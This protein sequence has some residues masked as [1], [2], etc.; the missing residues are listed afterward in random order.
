MGGGELS[1][2]VVVLGKLLAM[3]PVG[4]AITRL[5]GGDGALAQLSFIYGTLPVAP[6]VSIYALRYASCT[7]AATN[8]VAQV[9][10]HPQ[11][12][13]AGKQA[14]A[15]V[16]TGCLVLSGP[17][18]LSS[19]TVLSTVVGVPLLMMLALA[20][21][22]LDAQPAALPTLTSE[23]VSRYLCWPA[24]LGS[25][26]VLAS[27]TAEGRTSLLL[28]GPGGGRG[29]GGGGGFLDLYLLT[30][31]TAAKTLLTPM[32]ALLPR[33]TPLLLLACLAQRVWA[34]QLGLTTYLRRRFGPSAVLR[35]W[36]RL[37]AASLAVVLAVWFASLLLLSASSTSVGS[38]SSSLRHEPL[39]VVPLLL[40]RLSPLLLALSL[41]SFL[42]LLA[43]VLLLSGLRPPACATTLLLLPL[44]A[45]SRR[46]HHQPASTAPTMRRE[47]SS[48]GGGRAATTAAAAAAAGG[49]GGE[50]AVV[51]NDQQQQAVLEEGQAGVV[52]AS[53]RGGQQDQPVVREASTSRWAGRQ[54]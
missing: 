33:L 53:L 39:R 27:L 16:L 9:P 40:P 19:A 11:H 14:G 12:G 41:P 1:Y 37:T 22:L 51:P 23:L 49:G 31:L 45:A 52:V 32:V 46:Q 36:P 42:L 38:S 8:L 7:D 35:L 10:P 24:L 2:G 4:Y 26:W 6:T 17:G 44:F 48:S 50:A 3:P 54:R 20:L 25:A 5:L 28:T 21:A 13:Q 30:A 29:G 15:K 43:L 47:S 34:L 18:Q